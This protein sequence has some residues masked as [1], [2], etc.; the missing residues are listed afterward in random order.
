LF[1]PLEQY[2]AEVAQYLTQIDIEA[3]SRSPVDHP[4]IP[5]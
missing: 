3:R 1:I 5:S 4:M 2:A